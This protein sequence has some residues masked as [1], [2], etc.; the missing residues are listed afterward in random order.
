MPRILI[1]EDSFLSRRLLSKT[2]K[3]EGYDVVEACNGSEGLAVLAKETIDCILLD[4]LMPEM[5][6]EAV[7]KTLQQRSIPTPVIV[8]SAD[9]QETT[10][11][12][13]LSLGVFAVLHKIVDPQQ[14][15]HT[16]SAALSAPKR[17][18]LY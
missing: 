5:D 4:L 17:G 15:L 13:C 9:I 10:R 2:L 14:L 3:S 16:L 11:Q 18:C 6:G 1:L 12:Q 8:I 7:L